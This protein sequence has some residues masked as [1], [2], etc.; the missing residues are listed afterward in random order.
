MKHL[1]IKLEKIAD[2]KEFYRK[3]CSYNDLYLH[4]GNTQIPANTFMGVFTL[5]L[6][7]PVKLV[8]PDDVTVAE[9][10]ANDFGKWVVK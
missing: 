1:T 7:Q 4:Q 10:V 9:R 5:D 6:E 8:M 2:V 3:A